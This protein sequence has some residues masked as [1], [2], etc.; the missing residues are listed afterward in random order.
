MAQSKKVDFFMRSIKESHDKMVNSLNTL[1]NA[2]VSGDIGDK[3][4]AAQ[5]SLESV[6]TLMSFM[7]KNDRPS[8]LTTL[9]AQLTTFSAGVTNNN[10]GVLVR[11][12]FTRYIEIRDHQWVIEEEDDLALDFDSLFEKYKAEQKLPELF[13]DIIKA[14]EDIYSSGAISGRA[15]S[16]ELERVIATIKL[17]KN[18]SHSSV[19]KCWQ[20][21]I[22]FIK[23]YLWAELSR[24]PMVGSAFEALE[25]A[26]RAANIGMTNIEAA[27]NNDVDSVV[28]T[29]NRALGF[30]KKCKELTYSRNG[31]DKPFLPELKTINLIA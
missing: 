15:M 2:L 20:F 4:N 22:D 7:S 13:D 21:M 12:F 6:M 30:E 11:F 5:A 16:D 18:G 10:S 28:S 29:S 19:N 14:L 17:S 27:I 3:R 25:K 1:S 8:W 31:T 9:H 23:E 26:L 24:L